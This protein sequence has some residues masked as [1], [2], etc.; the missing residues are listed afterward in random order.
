MTD[1]AGEHLVNFI[2]DLCAALGAAW[3]FFK[4]QPRISDYRSRRS[5]KSAQKRITRL[6]TRLKSYEGDLS[7]PA[8]Y[9][10]RMVINLFFALTWVI[11]VIGVTI[12]GFKDSEVIVI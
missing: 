4:F 11:V 7:D 2:L 5:V 3:L 1:W 8:R 6:E 9:I 12:L 10:G